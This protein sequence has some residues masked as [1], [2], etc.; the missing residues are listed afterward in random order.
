MR[1]AG[2][3]KYFARLLTMKTK[4]YVVL[5]MTLIS[6]LNLPGMAAADPL[7]EVPLRFHIVTDLKMD[8]GGLVMQSWLT[9]AEIKNTV[10]PELNR[11]WQPAGIAFKIEAIV[12]SEALNPPGR[13]ELIKY[14]VNSHRDSSGKSDRKRIK[15]LSQLIDWGRHNAAAINIYYVPY[16]GETSQGN[17]R[18]KDLRIFVGQWTDKPSRARH[19]PEKFQLTEGLPFRKGSLSRTTAHEIGHILGLKHPDR[20]TQTDFGLLMGGQKAGYRFTS[21]NI[22]ISRNNAEQKFGGL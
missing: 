8:K 7:I 14:V 22:K 20:N 11:I 12:K 21:D 19:V 15:K 16:L 2:S 17:A 18:P 9:Q 1:V 3:A 4:K 6:H 10:L 13:A 5:I